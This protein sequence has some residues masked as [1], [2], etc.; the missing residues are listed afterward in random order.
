MMYLRVST[1][2]SRYAGIM[3]EVELHTFWTSALHGDE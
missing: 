1:V 3:M 2:P